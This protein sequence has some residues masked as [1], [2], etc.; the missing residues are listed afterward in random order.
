MGWPKHADS[1][2]KV[3]EWHSDKGRGP[4]MPWKSYVKGP[5]QPNQLGPLPPFLCEQF[6]A[7][8]ALSPSTFID[9]R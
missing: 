2:D 9:L 7:A 6:A 5:L 4:I 3:R 8:I 1:A